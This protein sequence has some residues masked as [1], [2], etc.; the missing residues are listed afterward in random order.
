MVYVCVYVCLHI[1]MYVKNGIFVE[2]TIVRLLKNVWLNLFGFKLSYVLFFTFQI[3]E[4]ELHTIG[5]LN[6]MT[7]I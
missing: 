1:F 3:V 4:Y 6:M 2:T 5:S 7:Y